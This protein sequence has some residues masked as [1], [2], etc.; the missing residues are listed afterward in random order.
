MI[1]A[2]EQV[3]RL[4]WSPE[5]GDLIQVLHRGQKIRSRIHAVEFE[6]FRIEGGRYTVWREGC[7]F[8]P[9]MPQYEKILN[10]ILV[11]MDSLQ[12]HQEPLPGVSGGRKLVF[13]INQHPVILCGRPKKLLSR[14]L[15][16]RLISW[17][18]HHAINQVIFSAR[19]NLG[20][21]K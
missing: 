15:E 13:R 12:V 1:S 3:T 9:R 19:G 18:V 5:P 8:L 6:C 4:I 11:H 2:A 14:L 16:L 20:E 7:R 17:Q 21:F 10:Q